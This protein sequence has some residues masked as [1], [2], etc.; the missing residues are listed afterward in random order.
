MIKFHFGY[1]QKLFYKASKERFDN[2]EEFK[3]RSYQTV[4][5]LHVS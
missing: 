3:A 4:F 2:D 5:G 1:I